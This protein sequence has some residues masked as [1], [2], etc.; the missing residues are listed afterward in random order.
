MSNDKA[1]EEAVDALNHQTARPH[2]GPFLLSQEIHLWS[3]SE[4]H[5]TDLGNQFPFVEASESAKAGNPTAQSKAISVYRTNSKV[6]H[7]GHVTLN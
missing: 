3:G 2:Q 6:T 5:S 1:M 4:P 7:N